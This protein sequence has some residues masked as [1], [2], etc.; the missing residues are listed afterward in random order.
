MLSKIKRKIKQR[1]LHFSQLVTDVPFEL[2]PYEPASWQ[3]EA[4][5]ACDK[6]IK[7][8]FGG[9]R[10]GKSSTTSF[11][12]IDDTRKF[13]GNM[14]WAAAL[15]EDKLLPVWE[16]HKQFLSP[17]EIKGEPSWR[18]SGRIPSYVELI[19]EAGI[20]SAIEYKTWQSGAGSFSASDVKSI[21]LDE[22]GQRTTTQAERIFDDCQSRILTNR[23]FIYI[24]AT[25]VLGKNWMYERLM[26]KN[27]NNTTD[28]KPDKRIECWT[29]S[30]RDNKFIDKEAV[31]EALAG[32]SE[33]EIQRRFYGMFTTL[34]GA[35]FKEFREDIHVLKDPP[36]IGDSW[37]KIRAIDLGYE[38][39]FCCLWLALDDDGRIYF[40]DEYYKAHTLIK[41]HVA[42]IVQREAQ[43][44]QLVTS[45][46]DYRPIEASICDHERQTR[47]ELEA[48]GL[49]TVAADKSVE[50]GIQT[51]NRA[52]MIR[53]DGTPGVYISP[54]CKHLIHQMGSYH[55]KQV[56][57]GNENKEI[58]A[59]VDDHA[60]DPARYGV[61]YFKQAPRNYTVQ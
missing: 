21:Q 14:F 12:L 4:F 29:V 27:R 18:K 24:G 13:P 30:L 17:Y 49:F 41:D 20:E 48:C 10:S 25:P 11:Q 50:L 53:G 43:H 32:M 23:G 16:W 33:D 28:K 57:D 22:D 56:R 45:A 36:L 31:D 37:R 60:V 35:V 54:V 42:Y 38:N 52:L 2:P 46:L 26:L 34:S 55:Y 15:T 19:N 1:E 7:A 47:A 40:Y 39:P 3:A 61:Q 59:K 9:D 6:H 5:H 51:V 44:M 58:I 8:M